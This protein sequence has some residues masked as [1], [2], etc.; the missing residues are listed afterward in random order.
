[1][2]NATIAFLTQEFSKPPLV[3]AIGSL[4]LPALWIRSCCI[5]GPVASLLAT[6]KQQKKRPT[7]VARPILDT[8]ISF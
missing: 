7:F 6:R 2:L 3:L 5:I 8:K 1:M 4:R